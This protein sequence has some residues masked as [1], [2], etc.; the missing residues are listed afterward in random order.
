MPYARPTITTLIQ[1]AKQDIS[2]ANIG[3]DGFLRRA[4]LPLLATVQAGFAWLHYDYQD[5]I[6]LQAVPFTATAEFADG[7]GALKGV[8]RLPATAAT[9]TAT[10]SG[11]NGVT[12]PAATVVRSLSGISYTTNGSATVSSG[13]AT[14]TA[15]AVTPGS[16]SNVNVGAQLVLANPITGIVGNSGV[17]TA[18]QAGADVETDAAYKT[19]YLQAYANPPQGGALADYLEWALAVSGVT[20]AWVMPNGMGAGTVLVYTMFDMVRSSGG[21]F[22]VGTNGVAAAETRDPSHL[23]AGDQLLVANALFPLRPVTAL[24]YSNAPIN[25]P[26]NFS[27]TGLGSANTTANQTAITAALKDMFLRL[28]NVGGTLNPATMAAWPSITQ[29]SWF[30]AI[31]SVLGTTPYNVPSPSAPLTPTNG[32]LLTLGTVSFAS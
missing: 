2:A 31:S 18:T 1:Q 19:R 22:P 26:V 20:R 7:W 25:T 12:I 17:V 32:E 10:F 5:W 27:I 3:V 11:T 29:D 14:V 16:G 4:V 30:E 13:T 24:L 15:T 6:S 9:V 21:G 23:A 28:G 8:T